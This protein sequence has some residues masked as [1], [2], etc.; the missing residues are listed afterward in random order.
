MGKEKLESAK[1]LFFIALG[2]DIAI[3]SLVVVSD[4]WGA[5][6]LKDV[7][8]GRSTADQST[9]N[10]LEFWNSF[11][12]LLI[13]TLIGVGL[14]LV[15]WLNAC[16]SF[17]KEVIGASGFK[18]E[19]WTAAGWVIPVFNLFKP[20]LVIN[21]IYKAGDSSYTMP[22][23]W[24]KQAWSGLLLT[25]WIFWAVT[26][27]IAVIAGKALLKNS[28]RD[29]LT[30][31]QSIGMFEFHAWFCIVSLIIAG[32]WFIVAGGITRRLLARQHISVAPSAPVR[33]EMASAPA[34]TSPLTRPT[35][36]T[37]HAA[38]V[39][40]QLAGSLVTARP[41]DTTATSAKFVNE[42]LLPKPM[43]LDEFTEEEFWATAMTELETGQ[44]R[45]GLWA[46]A[47]AGSE[48][49]E[50]KAKVA[51]LKT[52]VQ[53]LAEAQATQLE[54][55]RK[56]VAEKAQANSLAEREAI[57]A[58]I[59]QFESAHS[60]SIS[61]IRQFV[62]YAAVDPRV[63]A[64]TDKKGNSVLHL[65]AERKMAEEVRALMQVGADP[66]RGNNNGIKAEFMTKNPVIHKLLNG[67]QVSAEQLEELMTPASGMCPNCGD[68]IATTSHTCRR[69]DIDLG[70]LSTF[71]VLSFDDDEQLVLKLKSEYMAGKKPTENQVEYLVKKS[72]A[73]RSLVA[74]V[75][76]FKFGMT[77]LHW[78]AHYDLIPQSK[79]LLANGARATAKN[80]AGHMPYEEC[81]NDELR[82]LLKTASE[83]E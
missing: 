58:L 77:L 70:P 75:E 7:S 57:N 18:N 27:L 55:Q 6:I 65:C 37:S 69:C 62:S 22:D 81:K 59:A 26:H 5:G 19:S 11:S 80:S 45:P 38:T 51:Y 39:P 73:F 41:S 31:E 9:I 79:V 64:V 82:Q 76:P 28:I 10:A 2:I 16:Y 14:G 23:G 66:Q 74:L 61:E 60:F 44:R 15:K 50:T 72:D 78:C 68:I 20:Y 3:T 83:R 32:L 1:N 49:D 35:V 54:A 46:K 29:D 12:K 25:W 43:N 24:K 48:G 21:E 53:Q 47:F 4:F 42:T 17:S 36:P 30:L 34:A 8:A 52:R 63:V 33:F 13:L 67:L 56:A 40:G 71:K